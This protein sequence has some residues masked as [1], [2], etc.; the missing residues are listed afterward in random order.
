[1]P[2]AAGFY[3]LVL[4]YPLTISFFESFRKQINIKQFQQ[5]SKI[6]LKFET[7]AFNREPKT[8]F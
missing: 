7:L 2:T 8:S 1:M 5:E 6:F 3:P 4:I